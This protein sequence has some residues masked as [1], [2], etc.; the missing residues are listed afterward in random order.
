MQDNSMMTIVLEWL[1][2]SGLTLVMHVTGLIVSAMYLTRL[3][4]PALMALGGC[5]L[6]LFASL[7]GLMQHLLVRANMGVPP[8]L[9]I[10]LSAVSW[11]TRLLYIAG[12]VLVFAAVFVDRRRPEL[13]PELDS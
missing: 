2:Y 4:R 12:F 9:T 13:P 6:C 3:P 7:S 10:L 8:E 5:G 11:V 1:S